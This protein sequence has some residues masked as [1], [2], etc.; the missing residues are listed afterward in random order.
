THAS[1]FHRFAWILPDGEQMLGYPVPGHG[2]DVTPG[3]RCY[4][5]VWY[6][7]AEE[8]RVLADMQTDASGRMHPEGIP[9]Q[10]VRPEVIAAMRRDAEALFCPTFA[11]VVRITAHPLFQPIYDLESPRI[12]FGR[13]ALLGDAAFVVRPH[14]GMGA[15]KAAQDA[16]TLADALAEA[17]IPA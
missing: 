5:F 8:T 9:P 7:P 10:A 16:M 4:N 12:V 3:R 6:R 13:V 15:I 14:V 1:L 2:D 11:E 17:P